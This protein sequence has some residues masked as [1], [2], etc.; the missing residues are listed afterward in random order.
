MTEISF[1]FNVAMRHDYACRIARKA[2]RSGA[3][4]TVAGPP[5][6]LAEFDRQLWAFGA[7]E[8]VPHAWAERSAEVPARLHPTTVWLSVSPAEAPSHDALLNLGTEVPA[9]FESFARVYEIVSTAEADRQS[10]RVRWKRYADR[11]Y[12][13]KRHEVAAS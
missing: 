3:T 2:Q 9:G 4:L 13:I 11:G 8:F 12:S 1:Y 6:V 7:S 5:E 10:A